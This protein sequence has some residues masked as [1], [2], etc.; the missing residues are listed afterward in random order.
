MREPEPVRK[1]RNTCRPASSAVHRGVRHR[2]GLHGHV[3]HVCPANRAESI[4]TINAA[5]DAGCSLID[6][7]KF[8]GMGH[9][10]MLIAEALKGV[11]RDRYELGVKFGALRGPAGS[12]EGYDARPAAV[13]TWLA[14]SLARL[15][16]D[17]S[18]STARR[19]SIRM[20][21]SRIP[22]AR[23]RTS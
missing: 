23:S 9:N 21:R 7:G 13:K 2:S 10:E 16:V 8:Y 3:G 14:Y 6:I 20:C 15:G 22:W 12:W 4:A 19:G 5:L 18:T 1:E 17:I 11:P